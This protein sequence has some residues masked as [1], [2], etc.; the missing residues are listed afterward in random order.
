MDN[1]VNKLSLH[2]ND[3]KFF[4]PTFCVMLV[5]FR[6]SIAILLSFVFHISF[7]RQLVSAVAIAGLIIWI[8]KTKKI[9]IH[10]SMLFLV[11]MVLL[12][13]F[14]ILISPNSR[15]NDMFIGFCLYCLVGAFSIY[16][17]EDSAYLIRLFC[18]GAIVLLVFCSPLPFIT[19]TLSYMDMGYISNGMAYGEWIL[20]PGFIALHLIR[21]K[22][23][24]KW[25]IL[26][27]VV[28]VVIILL[29][30]NRGSILSVIAFLACYELLEKR[31]NWRKY[32]K[33]AV[34][35][36][37]AF[38]LLYFSEDILNFVN[39]RILIPNGLYSRSITR[40][41]YYFAS[42]G[43]GMENLSR[44]RENTG[45][46]A[47]QFLLEYPIQGIGVGTFYYLTGHAYTHN[48]I[49]D[50][51]TTF[52]VVFGSLI[53]IITIKAVINMI[54]EKDESNKLLLVIFFAQSFPRLFFSQTFVT[55]VTY[56]MFI[57]LAYTC[58]IRKKKN[59]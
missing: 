1:V 40:M 6:R 52:G 53:L 55:D 16:Y 58:G 7:G 48:F 14:S 37:I 13:L 4:L 49:T 22:Y 17:A 30:A 35:I 21:N 12:I 57:I 47:L 34:I 11:G 31:S 24:L 23:S 45:N 18:W 28:V 2:N 25:I 33:W 51:L 15:A 27:Q 9:K 32:L 44:G 20:V 26:L 19:G 36:I 5:F 8:L 42:E 38:I 46:A 41:I 59:E 50:A 10:M 43:K 56:W 29:Y 3:K 54:K 39:D